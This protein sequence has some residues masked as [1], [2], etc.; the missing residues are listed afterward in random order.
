MTAQPEITFRDKFPKVAKYDIACEVEGLLCCDRSGQPV[1]LYDEVVQRLPD[2][3]ARFCHKEFLH[4]MLELVT[5]PHPTAPEL[6]KQLR[7][8]ESDTTSVLSPL[9]ANVRWV[10]A[11]D[12]AVLTREMIRDYNRTQV[13]LERVGPM[14]PRLATFGL[15]LHV[16]VDFGALIGVLKALNKLVPFFTA[17]SANSPRM[18]CLNYQAASHR[19]PFWAYGMP[20]SGWPHQ[21]RDWDH[22]ES[23]VADL[24]RLG[25]A[26]SPK[27]LHWMVRPTRFGTVELRCCDM[28]PSLDMAAE[29]AALYQ[30]V[31][32]M[33]ARN[34][35]WLDAILVAALQADISASTT[36]GAA[37]VLSSVTGERKAL[38]EAFADIKRPLGGV[39][40]EIKARELVDRLHRRV[41]ARTELPTPTWRPPVPVASPARATRDLVVSS[42]SIAASWLVAMGVASSGW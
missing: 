37:A 35:G 24:A 15:H 39:L 30:A 20:T 12:N 19:F 16:G 40:D 25:L 36:F 21:W 9:G 28:P 13:T 1:N 2:R 5:S 8:F 7:Q 33:S 42:A 27:D 31:V 11:L 41:A 29:I 38:V 32:I 22:L 18:S 6:R 23:H 26:S 3:T 17:L 34:P 14:V 10:G 4:P